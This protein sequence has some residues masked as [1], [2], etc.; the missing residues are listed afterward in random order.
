MVCAYDKM[1]MSSRYDPYGS[2]C[3][4]DGQLPD[5]DELPSCLLDLRVLSVANPMTASPA[6]RKEDSE[7]TTATSGCL[8]HDRLDARDDRP[9]LGSLPK[10][11]NG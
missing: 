4:S 11:Y 3:F 7:S 6:Y 5:V 2:A 9:L 1:P 10:L 8:R